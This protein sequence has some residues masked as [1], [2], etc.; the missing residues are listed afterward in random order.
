MSTTIS[1]NQLSLT[2]LNNGR[3]GASNGKTNVNNQSS[4]LVLGASKVI[5]P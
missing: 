3:T 5:V 1:N 4:S 2:R